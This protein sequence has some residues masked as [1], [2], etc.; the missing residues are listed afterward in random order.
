MEYVFYYIEAHL[1]CFFILALI[2]YKILK[3]VNKQASSIYIARLIG[4]LMLY[5]LAEIFW[6]LVDGRVIKY[7]I[8]LTYLSNVFTYI[9]I[10]MVTYNWFIV[11]ESLQGDG[12]VEDRKK[13]R[14]VL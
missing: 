7:S 13:R 12:I 3:A 10:T 11:S 4:I 14:L 2:Y 9:L 5:F 6:V 8:T 1:A